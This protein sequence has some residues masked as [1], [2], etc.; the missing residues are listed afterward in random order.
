MCVVKEG[1]KNKERRKNG[2][3]K[4]AKVHGTR[5]PTGV[6]RTVCRARFLPFAERNAEIKRK[7]KKGVMLGSVS[8]S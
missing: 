1:T 2:V 3:G 8:T 7:V 4:N 5:T 6:G